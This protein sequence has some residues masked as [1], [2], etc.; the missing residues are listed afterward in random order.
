MPKHLGI[1]VIYYWPKAD[2]C[3]LSKS[4]SKTMSVTVCL[5]N[6]S[7]KTTLMGVNVENLSIHGTWDTQS[8]KID[9][10][11]IPITSHHWFK[12][13]NFES[14]IVRFNLGKFAERWICFSFGV[15]LLKFE[16]ILPK[17]KSSVITRPGHTSE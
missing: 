7:T 9:C 6:L 16:R 12:K 11:S 5:K 15:L 2:V 13:G 8:P 1:L 14:I 17:I 4:I 3:F 10:I